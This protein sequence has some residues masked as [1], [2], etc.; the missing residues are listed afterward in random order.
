MEKLIT[1]PLA[2]KIEYC[3]VRMN[4][5]DLTSNIG[6]RADVSIEEGVFRNLIRSFDEKVNYI[7]DF[8]DCDGAI[9]TTSEILK[10][11]ATENIIILAPEKLKNAFLKQQLGVYEIY[12]EEDK[13]VFSITFAKD[14]ELSIFFELVKSQMQGSAS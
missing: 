1:F 9:N 8:S 11:F 6:I 13:K 12:G 7:V 3:S 2:D 14:G 4:N 10:A 5:N